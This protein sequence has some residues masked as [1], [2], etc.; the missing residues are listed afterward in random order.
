MKMKKSEIKSTIGKAVKASAKI[1][2]MLAEVDKLRSDAQKLLDVMAKKTCPYEKGQMFRKKGSNIWAKMVG[3]TA[4]QM[5]HGVQIFNDEKCVA[6]PFTVDCHRCSV[7]GA[8]QKDKWIFIQ[9][10]KIGSEWEV[11]DS[12]K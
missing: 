2:A 6:A 7:K 10:Y 3:V 4:V 1:R 8:V 11:V 9:G 12:G 5:R